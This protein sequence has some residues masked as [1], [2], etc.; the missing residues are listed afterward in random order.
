MDQQLI[1]QQLI[2]WMTDFVEKP[3]PLLNGWAPCPYARQAR[4][5]NKFEIVFSS[6]DLLLVTCE[7]NLHKLEEKDVIIVCFD[8]KAVPVDGLTELVKAYNHGFLL[9]RNYVILEDHPDDEEVIN[10][11]RMNFGQCGLLLLS[12]LSVLN[13]ASDQLRSKGY[14]DHWSKENLDSVVSWR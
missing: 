4:I 7:Q 10:G 2:Q 6:H 3:N 9:P 12:K 13:E 11:V 5:N 14:Y 1:T 8:H